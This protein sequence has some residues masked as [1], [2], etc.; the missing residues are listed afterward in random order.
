[1]GS[2]VIIVVASVLVS[3][4]IAVVA[5]RAAG[6]GGPRKKV[7]ATGKPGQATI[8]GLTPTGTVINEINY[9]VR[10]QLRVQLPGQAPYDV[11]T[12]ETVPIT[13]MAMLVPG[14]VV[15]VR[16]DQAKPEL[17]FIDWQQ[18]V[19]PAGA[20]GVPELPDRRDRPGPLAPGAQR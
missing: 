15:S 12:K 2:V 14:T 19:T 11:E 1:M 20:G 16:V 6:I 17:V 3:I 7:L 8:M 9:V 4:V 5:L 10:F 13:S 18:G